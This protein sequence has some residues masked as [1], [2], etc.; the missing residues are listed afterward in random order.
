MYTL[1]KIHDVKVNYPMKAKLTT[2]FAAD[3]NKYKVK[4][5]KL[6]YHEAEDFKGFTFSMISEKDKDITLLLEY[7]TSKKTSRF[8]FI[9]EEIAYDEEKKHY[10]SEMKAVLKWVRY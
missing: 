1:A 9:L 10:L 7:L 3:L 8:H 4:L 2:E 6:S 5:Q